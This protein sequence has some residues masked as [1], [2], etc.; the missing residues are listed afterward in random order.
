LAETVVREINED[1]GI[2]VRAVRERDGAFGVF[3]IEDSLWDEDGRL[4]TQADGHIAGL[5]RTMERVI[6]SSD[7]E[8]DTISV[9]VA[10]DD[11]VKN[12]QFERPF[13]EIRQKRAGAI[14]W[15]NVF[16]A[17][18]AETIPCWRWELF[19]ENIYIHAGL[20]EEQLSTQVREL[21][22]EKTGLKA[23]VALV[24]GTLGIAFREAKMWEEQELAEKTDLLLDQFLLYAANSALKSDLDIKRLSVTVNGNDSEVNL[25]RAVAME[26]IRAWVTDAIDRDTLLA[27]AVQTRSR[28]WEWDVF[29]RLPWYTDEEVRT[30]LQQE[31]RLRAGMQ[32]DVRINADIVA[33][34][35]R[36]AQPDAI[37]TGSSLTETF[38]AAL[39]AGVRYLLLAQTDFKELVLRAEGTAGS[40]LCFTAE[41]PELVDRLSSED[42]DTSLVNYFNAEVQHACTEL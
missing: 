26:D 25:T 4:Q 14:A 30:A 11:S 36:T 24:N 38:S 10:G 13:R 33:I 5:L 37:H 9:T 23:Q 21:I 12:L 3:Y 17:E 31:I 34:T 39:R 6:I 18:E 29:G 42:P 8:I 35:I 1:W 15:Q 7:A 28:Y 40:Q 2:E 20:D 27:G 32:A 41:L 19:D 22:A 16:D